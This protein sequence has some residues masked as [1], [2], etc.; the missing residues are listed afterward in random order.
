MRFYLDIIS[1]N[2]PVM[3]ILPRCWRQCSANDCSCAKNSLYVLRLN[4]SCC[5][6]T[7]CLFSSPSGA[8]WIESLYFFCSCP[9][10]TGNCGEVV[11]D[12]SQLCGPPSEPLW[13]L[14]VFLENASIETVGLSKVL[15]WDIA[16]PRSL[17]LPLAFACLGAVFQTCFQGPVVEQKGKIIFCKYSW[18]KNRKTPPSDF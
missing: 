6:W 4:L 11:P 14:C 15:V 7:H 9:L 10:I 3:R 13:F 18:I 2:P 8:S 12:P 17:V 1:W 5:T 16:A